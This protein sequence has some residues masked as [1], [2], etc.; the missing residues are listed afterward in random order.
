[1]PKFEYAP[2]VRDTILTVVGEARKNGRAWDEALMLSKQ[3]GYNG[4]IGGLQQFVRNAQKRAGNNGAGEP[5]VSDSAEETAKAVAAPAK[6]KRR[7]RPA[8]K[9]AVAP[10]DASVGAVQAMI[11]AIVKKR[12]SAAFT[13]VRAALD[14]AERGV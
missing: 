10:A 1:M 3:V 5:E 12:L 7:G 8:K 6:Q 4:S 2:E 9:V 14:E 11:D 13:K